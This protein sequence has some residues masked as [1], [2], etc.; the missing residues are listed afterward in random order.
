MFAI[1]AGT[2]LLLASIG[3]YG[4]MSYA[5]S[6]RTHELGVRMAL[7][8]RREDV[9]GLVLGGALR[10]IGIGLLI[11]VPAALGL[12]QLL[13]GAL[14]GVSA[15]DPLTF[16]L[17]PAVLASVALAATYVPA[18]RATRVDPATALRST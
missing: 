13:R 4:V 15:T 9:L 14:Y 2:A 10:L 6:Q 17:I 5:V 8:A 12:S 16:I 3:L 7:G 11:G 18:R 1:F